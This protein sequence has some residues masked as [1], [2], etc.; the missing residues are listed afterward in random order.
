MIFD[1]PATDLPKALGVLTAMI[2]PALLISASG[3]FILSTSNRLGRVVDRARAVSDKLEEV[4]HNEA[5]VELFEERRALYLMQVQ[6][7]TRRA[8][9]LQRSLTVFYLGAGMFV[10]TSVALGLLT[11]FGARFTWVP[12]TFALAGG[13][14][15]FYGSILLIVEARLAFQALNSETDFL[16]KL[17]RL[18]S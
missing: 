14:F 6:R 4:M 15:L 5:Q 17:V 13:G 1:L 18:H 7:L 2:T 3:T 11:L 12:V 8:A 16:M 9:L 10:I